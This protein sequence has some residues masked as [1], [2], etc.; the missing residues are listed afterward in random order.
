VSHTVE[1]CRRCRRSFF[2][3]TCGSTLDFE[4]EEETVEDPDVETESDFDADE[5][6]IDPEYEGE[7]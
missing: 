2:E 5:L 3:C 4:T 6:G 7:D 1:V